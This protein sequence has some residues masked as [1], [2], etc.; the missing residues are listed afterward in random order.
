VVPIAVGI[1][2]LVANFDLI[3]REYLD[4]AW[5]LWPLIPLGTGVAILLRRRRDDPAV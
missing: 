2:G 5:K 3:P 1:V 4:Q